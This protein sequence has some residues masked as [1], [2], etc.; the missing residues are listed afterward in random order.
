M[1][2]VRTSRLAVCSERRAPISG[3]GELRARRSVRAEACGLLFGHDLLD[4]L[5]EMRCETRGGL[6]DPVAV[7][8]EH[9]PRLVGASDLHAHDRR[10]PSVHAHAGDPDL[11]T[12]L[13]AGSV[14]G[15][16]VFSCKFAARI[17]ELNALVKEIALDLGATSVDLWPALS[18]SR[19]GLRA[20][21]T[22]DM[23]QLNG[24]DYAAWV[25]TLSPI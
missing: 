22:P 5:A 3:V 15:H 25:D 4:R 20:E 10:V 7:L 21:S 16:E 9:D 18:D 13:L 8:E 19:G 14:E 2:A 12:G 24:L 23:L 11:L 1:C 17:A 6:H